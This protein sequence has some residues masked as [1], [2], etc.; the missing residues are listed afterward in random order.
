MIS[1]V[2][3]PSSTFADLVHRALTARSLPQWMDK[4]PAILDRQV[5]AGVW[6]TPDSYTAPTPMGTSVAE[7]WRRL[8]VRK[9][10]V[11]AESLRAC[12]N[13]NSYTD[14]AARIQYDGIIAS[15]A[16]LPCVNLFRESRRVS[17]LHR[18]NTASFGL[19]RCTFCGG[20]WSPDPLPSTFCSALNAA[21][22]I[23]LLFLFYRWRSCLDH[24]LLEAVQWIYSRACRKQWRARTSDEQECYCA[25]TAHESHA[26]L[27]WA[28][29]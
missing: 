29:L 7:V 25:R 3:S 17:V 27:H 9:A 13:G 26:S 23:P 15:L 4:K 10:G 1:P 8:T 6:S 5:P 22:A 24:G 11:S 16:L 20:R 2:G 28:Y 19:V 18:T 14:R 12:R 21:G